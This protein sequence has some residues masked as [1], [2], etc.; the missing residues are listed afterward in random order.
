M[1]IP[2]F[3]YLLVLLASTLILLNSTI[4]CGQTN[5]EVLTEKLLA[6]A[7][8][9]KFQGKFDKA[10]TVLESGMA[11]F[12]LEAENKPLFGKLKVTLGHVLLRKSFHHN[13]VDE[14]AQSLF[15]EV[16][17]MA[18]EIKDQQLL[19]DAIYG[20]GYYNFK[21]GKQAWEEALPKLKE[22]LAIREKI[23]D[24]YGIS[25]SLF[26]IGVIHQRSGRS[27]E[28]DNHFSESIKYAKAIKSAFMEG[29][30]ERHI[31]YQWYLKNDLEKAMPHFLASLRLR[32]SLNY[33]D[34]A[35]FAA[36]TVGQ[37][38]EK[39]GKLEEAI[40]YLEQALK[41]A[42]AINSPVGMVRSYS[43]LGSIYKKLNQTKEAKQ[44]LQKTIEYAQLT[45]YHSTEK[46]AREM[47]KEMD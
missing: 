1:N 25:R 22:S 18:Q 28:A 6:I 12:A 24:E 43:T 27:D 39:Q 41:D 47:L 4:V 2:Q 44:M 23:G 9:Y 35:I 14:V 5:E 46:Q 20:L 10:I 11:I 36:V 3:K 31:G 7:Q 26:T 8:D 13:Q 40:P 16:Y 19:A 32:R 21:Q 37:M 15:Q 29:E 42:I 17:E 45:G 30:N 38:L 33:I 34:G